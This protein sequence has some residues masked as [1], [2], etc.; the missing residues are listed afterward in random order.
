MKSRKKT[1]ILV[2]LAGA[3]VILGIACFLLLQMLPSRNSLELEIMQP[4]A[5]CRESTGSNG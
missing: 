4:W 3:V 1:V 5:L 2:F